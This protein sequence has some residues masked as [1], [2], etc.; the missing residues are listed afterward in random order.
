MLAA[1]FLFFFGPMILGFGSKDPGTGANPTPRP[2]V[3]ATDSPEPT[4]PPPPTPR[5]Y[6]VARG[7]TISKIA[8]KFKITAEVLLAANPQIKNPDKI[9]IG[10]KITIP[11]PVEGAGSGAGTGTVVGSTEP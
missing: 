8:A 3:V 9:K 7:D 5:I 4:T 6:T 1:L 11:V 10:D 2:T